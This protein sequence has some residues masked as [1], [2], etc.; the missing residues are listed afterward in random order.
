MTS[1]HCL[2]YRKQF[3]WDEDSY[4]ELIKWTVEAYEDSTWIIED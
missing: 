4:D 3:I 2:S 1:Y